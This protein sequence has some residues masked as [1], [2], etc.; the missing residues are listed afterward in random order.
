MVNSI[1]CFIYFEIKRKNIRHEIKHSIL[2]KLPDNQLVRIINNEYND[3]EEFEMNGIMY[4]VMRKEVHDG[5]VILWCFKDKKETEL[6][7]SIESMV[8]KDVANSPI[9]KTQKILL[10]FLKTPLSIFEKPLFTFQFKINLHIKFTFNAKLLT[11][12]LSVASPPPD[13]F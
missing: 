13:Y 9:K 5:Q 4:D 1:G 11:I 3:K 6:N 8:K 10:N 12:F 2:H 7:R